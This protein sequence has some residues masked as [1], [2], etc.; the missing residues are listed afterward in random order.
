MTVPVIV[1]EDAEKV[2]VS[3]L[4][5]ALALRSEPYAEGV[6][7]HARLPKAVPARILWVREVNSFR[8]NVA[9]QQVTFTIDVFAED[10]ATRKRLG[11]LAEGLIYAAEGQV[12]EGAT[13][14]AP[15][16][17]VGPNEGPNPWVSTETIVRMTMTVGIRRKQLA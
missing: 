5:T 2:L 17:N 1:Q 9:V 15:A 6:E 13:L 14:Y 16:T 12:S 11:Y 3:Y 10:K 7:V 4:R 8:R